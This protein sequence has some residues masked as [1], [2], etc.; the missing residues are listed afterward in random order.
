MAVVSGFCYLRRK[1]PKALQTFAP[2]GPFDFAEGRLARPPS[3][4]DMG[5]VF[6]YP[7]GHLFRRGA[8]GHA[9]GDD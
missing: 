7:G 6:H 9:L 8:C 5:L 4:T 2:R 3:S 1:W